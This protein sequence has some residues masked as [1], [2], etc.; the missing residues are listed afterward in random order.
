S[1]LD[2]YHSHEREPMISLAGSIWKRKAARAAFESAM[3]QS[4]QIALVSRPPVIGAALLARDIFKG[5][6]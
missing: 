5:E 6:E 2:R 4:T 1:H 3:P